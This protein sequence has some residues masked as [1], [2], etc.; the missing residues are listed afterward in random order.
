V[1]RAG[2]ALALAVPLALALAVSPPHTPT[3][4]STPAGDPV[5]AAAGDIA[6]A[7]TVPNVSLHKC[8]EDPTSALIMS[9]PEVTNV[10]TLGD[11]QYPCG[12]YAKFLHGYDPTWGRL[13]ASTQP[14]IGNHEYET[15]K[16]GCDAQASGYFQYFGAA[17]QPN[18]ADG[19]YYFDIAGTGTS[20]AQ[21]RI[22]VL[23]ANCAIVSCA[24]GSAQVQFLQS[25]IASAPQGTRIMAAWHQPY[26]SGSRLAPKTEG[27]KPFWDDLYAAHAALVLNGHAHYYERYTPQDPS[28]VPDPAGLTE[29]IAGTGGQ[30]L[31][32]AKVISPNTM[33]YEN[34]QFGVL[35]VTLHD[36]SF[37][38][39][40][41]DIDGVVR[42][43]GTQALA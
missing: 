27:V 2:L 11:N 33:S 37:D 38:W 22:I 9:H 31:G 32:Q 28:G 40:F 6:C 4:A 13:L 12:S 3:R 17:A 19:Y 42:D 41:I 10:L 30:S 18:G 36:S 43:S 16:P 25:A 7:T 34:A 35:F 15:T 1:R 5:I 23:N 20:T 24:K 26:F 21:W 29:I 39:E 8:Y 14:T